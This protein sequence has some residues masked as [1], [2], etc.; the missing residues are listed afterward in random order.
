MQAAV[1]LAFQKVLGQAQCT[2]HATLLSLM[3]GLPGSGTKSQ[4]T[5]QLETMIQ[6]KM[7]RVQVT[8]SHLTPS[9]AAAQSQQFLLLHSVLKDMVYKS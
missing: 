3:I 7:V 9:K 1:E 4:D 5:R 6:M 2:V 8:Q